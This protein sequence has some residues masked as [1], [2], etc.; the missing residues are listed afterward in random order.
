MFE[1][2]L[3]VLDP[4]ALNSQIL[5][6]LFL[7]L[8]ELFSF[9]QLAVMLVTS[10]PIHTGDILGQ[11]GEF[12]LV[13][14]AVDKL[15]GLLQRLTHVN[16][17]GSD[18]LGRHALNGRPL[19]QIVSLG[20]IQIVAEVKRLGLVVDSDLQVELF[21]RVDDQF[22]QAKQFDPFGRQLLEAFYLNSGVDLRDL[23][24]E[25]SHCDLFDRLDV[26][27]VVLGGRVGSRL[28]VVQ[29]FVHSFAQFQRVE[30]DLE[31][32]VKIPDLRK[33]MLNYVVFG[34]VLK[35]GESSRRCL[36]VEQRAQT[37]KFLE[38]DL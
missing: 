2:L 13:V 15:L 18:L 1:A 9:E 17:L 4:L 30:L 36:Q 21:S 3:L 11:L 28:Q 33:H 20:H 14:R 12:R 5:I 25:A 27:G 7:F 35:K 23:F 34:Q 6:D 32:L 16:Q 29:T 31:T 19:G 10:L 38:S 8:D 24:E 22:L 26:L 37:F